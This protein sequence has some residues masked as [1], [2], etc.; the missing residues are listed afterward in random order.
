MDLLNDKGLKLKDKKGEI[1]QKQDP[2]RPDLTEF[3][4]YAASDPKVK[5]LRDE[6]KQFHDQVKYGDPFV[7]MKRHGNGK[8]LAVMTTAGKEWNEWGGGSESSIFYQPFIWESINYLTS[9]EAGKST[10]V[11][12]IVGSPADVTV[13]PE[14]YRQKGNELRLARFYHK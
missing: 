13:D 9:Q 8:V 14:P 7:I 12:R 1:T 11:S 4:A 6:I 3:W 5:S 2:K 10:D